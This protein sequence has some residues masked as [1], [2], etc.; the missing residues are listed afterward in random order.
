M[1]DIAGISFLEANFDKDGNLQNAVDLPAGTTD[2]FIMSHGW[3]N[4]KQDAENLYDVFFT[5]LPKQTRCNLFQY[6]VVL[7]NITNRSR[8]MRDGKRRGKGARQNRRIA[9]RLNKIACVLRDHS[10]RVAKTNIR[11]H[12]QTGLGG[13]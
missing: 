6:R 10:P 12:H 5:L 1:A 4:T 9:P 3:N 8:H 2:V 11:L 13:R 7:A